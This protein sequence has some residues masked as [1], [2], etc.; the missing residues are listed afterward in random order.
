MQS[1]RHT[2]QIDNTNYDTTIV[3]DTVLIAERAPPLQITTSSEVNGYFLGVSNPGQI[4]TKIFTDA[5]SVISQTIRLVCQ[6]NEWHIRSIPIEYE[7]R[8]FLC[9]L[10][11]KYI[12][13]NYNATVS[14]LC[15]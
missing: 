5:D 6:E 1:V 2:D 13:E 14:Y 4:G 10:V 9:I 7:Q 12:T 15:C 3:T 8:T 11:A